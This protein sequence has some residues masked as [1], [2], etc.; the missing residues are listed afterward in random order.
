VPI[1]QPDFSKLFFD[2]FKECPTGVHYKVRSDSN[3]RHDIQFLY[4]LV[5]D[6]SF[7]PSGIRHEKQTLVIPL[8]RQRGELREGTAP[9]K[10]EDMNSEL[11]FTRVKK[12]EWTA[13]QVTRN[14]P[15]VGTL[16]GVDDTISCSTR[17]D[18]DA[19]FVGES[20]HAPRSA[21]VE[22]VIAGYPGG[23]RLRIGLA[24]EGWTVAVKD[25]TSATPA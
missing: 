14:A 23:W 2:T 20:T 15:F 10:C 6:A 16:F 4:S 13:S 5:K 21:G 7:M 12:I 17:C 19:L 8:R 9:A 22:I 25:G 24:H 1:K 18:I 11:R 3:F